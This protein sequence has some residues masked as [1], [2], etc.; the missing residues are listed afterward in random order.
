[1][2]FRSI[3]SGGGNIN[4]DNTVSVDNDLTLS[5]GNGV[6][7]FSGAVGSTSALAINLGG[8]SVS[9]LS[10]LQ[11]TL[12]GLTVSGT[13]G[14]TLPALTINGPQIYDTGPITVTGNLG[15]SGLT[16]DNLVNVV[17][18]VG[19]AIAM[20]AGIG[21]LA[22]EGQATLNAVNMTL[23]AAAISFAGE[24][25]GTGSLTIQPYTNSANIAV[26]GSS[27]SFTGLNLTAAD[28]A[29]LPLT[30]LSSVTIGNASGTGSLDI[31]GPLSASS[32][33]LTL[34]GGG[35]ITQ[36]GG[37]IKAGPLTLYAATG[38]IDLPDAANSFGAVAINGTPTA[39]T[40]T[41]T[42]AI[43]QQGTAP[44]NLGA[45]N[46]TLNAGTNN[47]TLNNT[48]NTFGT[49]AVEGGNVQ[50]TEAAATD[51]GASTIAG[52]L[53][54][55]SSGGINVSGALSAGGNVSF[56]GTGEVTQSAPLTIGGNLS[57]VTSINAGDVTIDN[58]GATATTIG[59]TEVGG[60][61]TLTATG[62]Q[63]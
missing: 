18:A 6:L 14:I 22:F 55:N 43:T 16:F 52:N 45:A 2:L 37:S 11:S 13:A 28:L 56:T 46:L 36:S 51:I 5:T 39:V 24:V 35:G 23:T 30:T 62:Q 58:S 49:L 26:G 41:D 53:T 57:V 4:F 59:N 10:E 15:G 27:T 34:N 40:L 17:P 38:A 7:T 33:P 31:A 60:N 42:Q 9:G 50:V 8:G 44:W 54:V 12:T 29:E 47:I 48:G 21:T 61:Y 32:T 20:N 3:S 63:V 1:M 25:T 19:T